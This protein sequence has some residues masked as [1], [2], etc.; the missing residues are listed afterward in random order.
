MDTMS[1]RNSR[2]R[3]YIEYCNWKFLNDCCKKIFVLDILMYE[4]TSP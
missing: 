1:E 3:E 2:N 4:Q